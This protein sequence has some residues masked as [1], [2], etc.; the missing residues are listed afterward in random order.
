M[1]CLLH[2]CSCDRNFNVCE[3]WS[4]S[5][6]DGGYRDKGKN[7]VPVGMGRGR[8]KEEAYAREHEIGFNFD[9]IYFAFLTLLNDSN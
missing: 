9:L 8:V 5:Y 4:D 1:T 6:C 7:G 3:I 2:G